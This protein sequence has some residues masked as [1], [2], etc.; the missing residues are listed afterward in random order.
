MKRREL[1]AAVGAGATV[2]VA[3]CASYI[4]G[5]TPSPDSYEQCDTF[6]VLESDLPAPA[7]EEFET[8]Y[9]EGEYASEDELYLPN[10]IDVEET[11]VQR[12][13]EEYYTVDV[14]DR[15]EKNRVFVQP[16]RPSFGEIS[17]EL[18]NETGDDRTVSVEVTR[19]PA[20][21]DSGETLLEETVEVPANGSGEVT[22]FDR[23]LG[24][25]RAAI[26][27]DGSTYRV[28]WDETPGLES[29]ETVYIDSADGSYEVS[30]PD[31]AE[32]DQDGSAC[33][34]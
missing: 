8:A 15:G 33:S 24:P 6:A 1:L 3:G 20:W 25:Y 27:I 28:R 5:M 11:Y 14:S 17:L 31:Q 9:R 16:I 21:N 10:V 7:Q 19:E 22:A 12:G 30:A 13:P 29:L 2:T 26:S 34:W 4:P 32:T 18:M 23:V